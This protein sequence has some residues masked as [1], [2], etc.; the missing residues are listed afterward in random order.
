[1]SIQLFFRNLFKN[2]EID[3]SLSKKAARKPPFEFPIDLVIEISSSGT[4][5]MGSENLLIKNNCVITKKSSR[6]SEH[7][8][9]FS[10][11]KDQL[12][13]LFDILKQN[14]FEKIKIIE[15]V[16]LDAPSHSISVEWENSFIYKGES[17]ARY[18]H[19]KW[20]ET[21]ENCRFGLIKALREAVKIH[22]K[23]VKIILAD[24]LKTD[25]ENL[26]ISIADSLNPYFYETILR[27]YSD[28]DIAFGLKKREQTD[29][30]FFIPGYTELIAYR[31][32]NSEW[33]HVELI[34]LFPER[35]YDSFFISRENNILQ[36]RLETKETKTG[37]MY[38]TNK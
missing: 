10:L 4:F 33:E 38:P 3:N 17:Q 31:S 22:L 35:D 8:F 14:K 6:E 13:N 15:D 11:T 26:F 20:D 27:D 9:Q 2:K 12:K 37:F 21:Y 34:V 29:Q 16:R 7:E 5:R 23:P 25:K 19:K 28:E 1:M 36:Y 24:E 32:G 18:I 30:T